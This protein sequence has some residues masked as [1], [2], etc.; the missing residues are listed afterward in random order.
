MP[1][2]DQPFV[3]VGGRE[4]DKMVCFHFSIMAWS[5]AATLPT[6]ISTNNNNWLYKKRGQ[7]YTMKYS[8]VQRKRELS[9][10]RTNVSPET[11]I[12]IYN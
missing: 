1:A 6:F 3:E 11:I 4:V 10:Q 5:P 7:I 8:Y 2:V 9:S 12:H